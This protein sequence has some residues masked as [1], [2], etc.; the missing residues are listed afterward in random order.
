MEVARITRKA[1]SELQHSDN[2][3]INMKNIFVI[4]E[5]LKSKLLKAGLSS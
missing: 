3:F 4:V 1:L 5:K 2:L